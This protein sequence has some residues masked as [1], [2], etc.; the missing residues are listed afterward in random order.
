MGTIFLVLGFVLTAQTGSV[1]PAS[2]FESLGPSCTV[3]QAAQEENL[4][5][6]GW[7]CCGS[8]QRDEKEISMDHG[9]VFVWNAVL[10]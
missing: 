1:D 10:S 9:D 8:S 2:D 3:D 6:E 4:T 7:L 5:V